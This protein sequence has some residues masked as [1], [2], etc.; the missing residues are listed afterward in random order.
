MQADTQGD[1]SVEQ[2]KEMAA[3]RRRWEA[4]VCDFISFLVD[5]TYCD[6]YLVVV[7]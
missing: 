5:F 1:Y 3:A 2:V 6:G 7:F 4:L